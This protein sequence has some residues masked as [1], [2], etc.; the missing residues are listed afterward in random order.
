MRLILL[1]V[2]AGLL[3]GCVHSPPYERTYPSR[4]TPPP[5]PPPGP[6]AA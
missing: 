5:P 2:A 3:A 6:G 4:Q 1:L